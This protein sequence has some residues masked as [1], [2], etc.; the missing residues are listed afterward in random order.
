[1][2][3]MAQPVPPPISVSPSLA[4]RLSRLTVDQ[5]DRMVENGTIG[6]TEELELIEGLLVTKMGRNRPHVQAGKM[7]LEALLRI[8]PP[9]WH[10]AKE[11][12]FVASDWSKPEPDLALVRG[13]VAD[14]S[15]RDVTATD[16]GLVVEIADSSLAE[17]RH[18]MG[19]LYAAGGIPAYWIINLIDRRVE[20]YNDPDPA[21]GYRR[22]T[23]FRPGDEIP[24]VLDGL[25]AGPIPVMDLLP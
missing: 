15:G 12:P 5:Y 19:R 20:V 22:E 23:V 14:Y 25:D 18:V 4:A 21:G 24:V 2:S 13:R 11:D 9:G 10:V 3:S 7:G 16:L 1:M 6:D 8:V 17:D